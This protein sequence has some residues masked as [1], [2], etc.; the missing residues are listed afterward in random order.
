MHS[1]AFQVRTALCAGGFDCCLLLHA[2]VEQGS[3][4]SLIMHIKAVKC[5]DLRMYITVENVLTPCFFSHCS[6]LS[7]LHDTDHSFHRSTHRF[8]SPIMS[9]QREPYTMSVST[10]PHRHMTLGVSLPRNSESSV[11]GMIQCV[12][13]FLTL[14]KKRCVAV[15]TKCTF[16]RQLP[17]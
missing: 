11:G 6:Y 3:K 10:H 16:S 14:G 15:K 7:C 13:T 1:P 9:A 17:C 5:L 4:P 12:G 2:M 8:I